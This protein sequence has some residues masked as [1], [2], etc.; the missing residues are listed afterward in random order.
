MTEEER[1]KQEEQIND[2][3][4]QAFDKDYRTNGGRSFDGLSEAIKKASQVDP[5]LLNQDWVHYFNIFRQ[6]GLVDGDEDFLMAMPLSKAIEQAKHKANE[7]QPQI[8]Q[9]EITTDQIND[10]LAQAFERDYQ[11]SGGRSFE[12]L[13]EAIRIA[14]QHDPSLLNQDWVHY[15]NIFR[16]KGLVDGDEDFL[17]ATPLSKAVENAKPKTNEQQQTMQ[18]EKTSEQALYEKVSFAESQAMSKFYG[19]DKFSQATEATK[20]QQERYAMLSARISQI[21]APK[22]GDWRF[23][24]N[25]PTELQ[26]EVETISEEFSSM[27]K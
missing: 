19:M 25:I 16:Q 8:M 22:N 6:K 9:Q 21:Y 18:P 17:M 4:A 23:N 7:Q 5:S 20:Q 24:V 14:S 13:E 11:I 26:Q 1:K 15:F 3:L 10:Y 2:Y 12:R 27:R